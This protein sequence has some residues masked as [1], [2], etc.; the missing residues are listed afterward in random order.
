MPIQKL[1]SSLQV[2]CITLS[3]IKTKQ[4][5]GSSSNS[6]ISIFALYS[7]HSKLDV[8]LPISNLGCSTCYEKFSIC[9]AQKRFIFTINF[10]IS[11][12]KDYAKK[13]SPN[14]F[15]YHYVKSSDY[16]LRHLLPPE[17]SICNKGLGKNIFNFLHCWILHQWKQLAYGTCTLKLL[18]QFQQSEET[19]RAALPLGKIQQTRVATEQQH[20]SRTTLMNIY[21]I[22]IKNTKGTKMHYQSHIQSWNADPRSPC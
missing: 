1:D 19:R 16:A 20:C 8:T 14:W 10:P 12:R 15:I 4:K 6:K 9:L 5:E 11:S 3:S 2:F 18:F 17:I 22:A 21:K 7:T 13:R